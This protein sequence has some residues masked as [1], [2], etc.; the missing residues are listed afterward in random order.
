MIERAAAKIKG[1]SET[2]GLS[3]TYAQALR[4]GDAGAASMQT[5]GRETAPTVTPWEEKRI[6]VRIA[7]G[8]QAKRVGEESREKIAERVESEVGAK[9]KGRVTAVTKLRSGDLAIHLCS[10]EAKREIEKSTEWAKGIAPTAEVK[11]RT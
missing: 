2:T 3:A 10:A 6:I 9:G 11:R 8:T 4:R 1:A 5:R 7:D